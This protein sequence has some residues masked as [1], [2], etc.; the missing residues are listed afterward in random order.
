MRVCGP[1][2]TCSTPEQRLVAELSSDP[3]GQGQ[4]HSQPPPRSMKF[5]LDIDEENDEVE[6]QPVKIQGIP[7]HLLPDF[8]RDTINFKSGQTP[9]LFQQALTAVIQQ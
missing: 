5:E 9:A 6:Y 2:A 1:V 4:Q 7:G 8:F 3:Q